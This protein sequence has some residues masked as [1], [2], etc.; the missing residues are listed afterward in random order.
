[1]VFGRTIGE[2]RLV[3]SHIDEGREKV[4]RSSW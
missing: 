3:S 2:V 4:C 1:M